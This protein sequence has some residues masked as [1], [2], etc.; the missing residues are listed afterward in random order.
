M[1]VSTTIPLPLAL[2]MQC[3]LPHLV[4]PIRVRPMPQKPLYYL[5]NTFRGTCDD[6]LE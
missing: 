4:K 3:I 5:G 6:R 1:Y 2:N